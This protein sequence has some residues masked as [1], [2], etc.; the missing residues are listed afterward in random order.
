MLP[1]SVKPAK[2]IV[3]APWSIAAADMS[4]DCE[5]VQAEAVQASSSRYTRAIKLSVGFT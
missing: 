2:P 5:T 4:I 3:T 1:G